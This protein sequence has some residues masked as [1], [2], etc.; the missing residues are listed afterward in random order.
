MFIIQVILF[1]QLLTFSILLKLALSECPP[2]TADNRCGPSYGGRC[3]ITLYP[4]A[5]YCNSDSGWCSDADEHKNAQP[6]EDIYDWN[7]NTCRRKRA[8]IYFLKLISESN[9]NYF[10]CAE[11][12]VVNFIVLI[13]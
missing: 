3:N 6:D 12:L 11:F 4:Q 13:V 2:L 5:L 10:T 7:P 8:L 9:V 1:L